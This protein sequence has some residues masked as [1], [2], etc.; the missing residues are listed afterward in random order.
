MLLYIFADY[1]LFANRE[2]SATI[3]KK[4]LG[5]HAFQ[6]K[7]VIKFLALKITILI[8]ACALRASF[9]NIFVKNQF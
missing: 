6:K 7:I 2:K 4:H 1:F 3:K 8:H 5:L 9:T